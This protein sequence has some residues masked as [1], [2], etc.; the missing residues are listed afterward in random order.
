MWTQISSKLNAQYD[1]SLCGDF[2]T[3]RLAYLDEKYE[4]TP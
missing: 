3:A 1:I 4:Y 2:I